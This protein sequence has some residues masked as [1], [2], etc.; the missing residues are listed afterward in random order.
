MTPEQRL[1]ELEE[2]LRALAERWSQDRCVPDRH[3]DY[4]SCDH[5]VED[6]AREACASELRALLGKA[7][8]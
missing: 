6:V 1:A 3:N 2:R 5:C 7:A 8:R 4:S